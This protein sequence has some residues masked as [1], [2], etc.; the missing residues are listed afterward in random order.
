MAENYAAQ[1]SKLL[2]ELE[3]LGYDRKKVAEATDYKLKTFASALARGGNAKMLNKI[4]FL[5]KTLEQKAMNPDFDILKRVQRIEA[6]QDVI[7]TALCDV[8]A[9]MNN[10]SSAIIK[11]E[12]EKLIEEVPRKK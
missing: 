10:R 11:S 4:A 1:I 8:L 9:K 5:K 7:L 2:D 12:Y 6:M 3:I